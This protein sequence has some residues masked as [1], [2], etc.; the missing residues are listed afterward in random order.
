[1]FCWSLFYSATETPAATN[2]V[3]DKLQNYLEH[4]DENEVAH[5]KKK[6]QGLLFQNRL[7]IIR[8]MGVER[9]EELKLSWRADQWLFM[10]K[11]QACF[12]AAIELF[13]LCQMLCLQ[14]RTKFAQCSGHLNNNYNNNSRA[15]YVLHYCS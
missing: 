4:Y 1:M 5:W 10:P 9:W 2:Y 13:N 8:M 12:K 3:Q 15:Q 7:E 14:T 6:I 11:V